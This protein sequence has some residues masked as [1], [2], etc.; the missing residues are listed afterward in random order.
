M[1]RV[2]ATTGLPAGSGN[3]AI[4]EAYRPGTEPGKDRDFGLR[5]APGQEIAGDGAAG[6]PVREAPAGGTGGLY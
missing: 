4:W 5:G 1:Y 3:A 6:A 2:S